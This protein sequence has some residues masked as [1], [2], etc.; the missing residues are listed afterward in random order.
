MEFIK[1]ISFKEN[2]DNPSFVEIY[3]AKLTYLKQVLLYLDKV[4]IPAS[5]TLQYDDNHEKLVTWVEI[6]CED[7]GFK[8]IIILVTD[9]FNTYPEAN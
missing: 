7:D 6:E 9:G 2:I 4:S 3:E 5:I 8:K 1:L